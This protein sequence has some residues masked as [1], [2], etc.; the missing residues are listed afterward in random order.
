[1][2]YFREYLM[3]RLCVVQKEIDKCEGLLTPTSTMVF[4]K[5]KIDATKYVAKYNGAGKYQV[6][7][8]WQDQYVV[9]LNEQ[10]CSYRFWEI[11]DMLFVLYGTKVKMDKMLHMLMNG[12]I[13]DIGYHMESHVGRPKKKRKRG[14]DEPNSQACKLSRKYQTVTCSRA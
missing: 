9:N 14:V 8:T 11:T 13:L 3:K 7:N 4:D 10:I 6:T 12:S 1:M 2:R 5:I